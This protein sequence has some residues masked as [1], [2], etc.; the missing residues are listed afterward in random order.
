M[1]EFREPQ[2]SDKSK[3][4]YILS[5][6]RQIVCEFCF[7]N[8]FIWGPIFGTQISM[9][10]K[11]FLVCRSTDEKPSYSVPKGHGIFKECINALKKEA[12]HDENRLEFYS[13]TQQDKRTMEKIFPNKFRFI[14]SRHNFDYVYLLK[15]LADLKGKKYKSKRNHISYFEKNFDWSFEQMNDKNIEECRTMNEKWY[16]QN[17]E[18]K[19]DG[20]EEEYVAVN[21]A[22]DYF[23]LLNFEGGLIRADGK[24]VAFTIGE[25]LNNNTFCTHIEKAFSDVRGAYPTINREFSKYLLKNYKYVNRE[26]D[27][28]IEGIREAKLSY[29]PVR[30]E[31]KYRAIYEG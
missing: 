16:F 22:L 18:Q 6:D 27:M 10:N 21:R 13:V 14:E 31:V 23:N 20:I 8:I 24:V 3:V 2:I 7:G 11:D 9:C 17:I 4:D 28:G 12:E 26:E 25:R 29:H 30:L 5:H 1:R 19:N 15:D